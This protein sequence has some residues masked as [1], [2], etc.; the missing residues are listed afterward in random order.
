MSKKCFSQSIA[1]RQIFGCYY[2]SCRASKS[3]F[4]WV[5]KEKYIAHRQTASLLIF[6]CLW[7]KSF[8]GFCLCDYTPLLKYIENIY[9]YFTARGRLKS[10]GWNI[11]L[12]ILYL[13][14][15]LYRKQLANWKDQ[16]NWIGWW[17]IWIGLAPL[18]WV[19]PDISEYFVD[20]TDNIHAELSAPI[21]PHRHLAGEKMH[22]L[23]SF[24]LGCSE[25]LQWLC[26]TDVSLEC[27]RLLLSEFIHQG[28]IIIP[29]RK[30]K[31]WLIF[32]VCQS[33]LK[34]SRAWSTSQ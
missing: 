6:Q 23:L 25:P 17:W 34:K 14:L 31:V 32:K 26:A 13:N 19:P 24:S 20:K 4:E 30:G 9:S 8:T 1:R 29:I 33:L 3:Y 15:Q 10:R 11:N 18:V 12:I 28:K 22:H 2:V 16:K 7:M 27:W 21:K 5:L